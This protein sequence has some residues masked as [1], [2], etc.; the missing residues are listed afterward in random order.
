MKTYK[1]R[2]GCGKEHNTNEEGII[3]GGWYC[4]DCWTKE[5]NAS[6]GEHCQKCKKE[7]TKKELKIAHGR[8]SNNITCDSCSGGESP[9][10]CTKCNKHFKYGESYTQVEDSSRAGNYHKSCWAEVERERNNSNLTCSKC[11][12]KR[13]G[14]GNCKCSIPTNNNPPTCRYYMDKD[15]RCGRCTMCLS[16][17]NGSD[18]RNNDDYNDREREREKSAISI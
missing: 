11:H 3:A 15:K 10:K 18:F 5:L 8:D 1:C 9:L 14:F 16:I 7:L 4:D 17:M 6:S 12:E 13:D 2:G